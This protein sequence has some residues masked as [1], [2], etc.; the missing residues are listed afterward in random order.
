MQNPESG[1]T[2]SPDIAAAPECKVVVF[3]FLIGFYSLTMT[4]CP[5]AFQK[6][7]NTGGLQ[8]MGSLQV[9]HD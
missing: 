1:R 7:K 6:T 5:M 4:I 2:R 3:R 9:G 8:S